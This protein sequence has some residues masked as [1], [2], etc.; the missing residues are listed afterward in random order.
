MTLAPGVDYP[1][2]G[3]GG[4][5]QQT[6]LE[7]FTDPRPVRRLGAFY[8]YSAQHRGVPCVVA[9]SRPDVDPEWAA[10][11]VAQVAQVHA[12]VNHPAVPRVV[13]HGGVGDTHY[14]AFHCDAAEDLAH[15]LEHTG[16]ARL[17]AAV[18]QGLLDTALEVF[19]EM[20]RAG[21]PAGRLSAAHILVGADGRPWLVGVGTDLRADQGVA[22]P[23]QFEAPE[24]AAWQMVHPSLDGYVLGRL[25]QALGA[26]LDAPPPGTPPPGPRINALID[27]DPGRRPQDYEALRAQVT[28]LLAPSRPS[29][30]RGLLSDTAA[31]AIVDAEADPVVAGRYRLERRLGFGRRGAFFLAWDQQLEHPV[32]LKWLEGDI[33][34]VERARLIREVSI[35]RRLRH[36]GVVGGFDLVVDGL[37]V[38]AVVEYVAGEPLDEHLARATDRLAVAARLAAVADA[39]DYLRR[40]GVVHRDVKP[41][42]IVLHP[43][44]D[45]VLVDLGLARGGDGEA[46]LTLSSERLG[47][48]R[49]MAP[50]QLAQP[51]V[52]PEA[53]V[54]GFCMVLMDT[55]AVEA[56]PNHPGPEL[57]IEYL[58]RAAVPDMLGALI[59]TGLD[60]TPSLRPRPAELA[61]ALRALTSVDEAA[62]ALRLASDGG[63]FDVDGARVDMRRRGAPRRI[64][65]ALVKAHQGDGAPL[66]VDQVLEAGWPDERILPD[67][68]R[69]RVYMAISTLRKLGLG[70][71]MERMDE[72][73]R[74]APGLSL[75]L[76]DRA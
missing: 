9:V 57:A 55:L 31:H 34:A 22:L 60:D 61:A 76:V 42:N 53:D 6:W 30:W 63:W 27:P 14:V 47:T 52:G 5:V 56:V 39:L 70:P 40:Q 15:L 50:E 32:T 71:L 21:L 74:F 19:E 13:A 64:L 10:Q 41:A 24:S 67:A 73:Y 17:P 58:S 69:A 66:T 48:F 44:R 2:D 59:A 62:G 7:R 23:W 28:D 51:G 45:A 8:L 18:G 54:Y 25:A 1:G 26:V 12:L 49:Y 46:S 3:L 33:S 72:G 75:Q 16:D 20:A 29:P 43:Q 38:G 35:L 65:M 4:R 68:G 37:R 11:V 36:P